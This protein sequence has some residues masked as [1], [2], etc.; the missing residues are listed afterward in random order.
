LHS[1]TN[2]TFTRVSLCTPFAIFRS[3]CKLL[4]SKTTGHDGIWVRMRKD[5]LPYIINTVT[6]TFNRILIEAVFAVCWKLA[7]VTPVYEGGDPDNPSN[8]CS[9]SVLPT[10]SKVFEKTHQC[11]SPGSIW[12]EWS[13]RSNPMTFRSRFSCVDSLQKVIADLLQ[14]KLNKYKVAL[15]FLNFSKAFHC[16]IEHRTLLSKIRRLLIWN[17]Q[18]FFWCLRVYFSTYFVYYLH[19]QSSPKISICL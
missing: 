14:C 19:W 12:S 11:L 18:C 13:F 3:P 16:R 6:D 1:H 17:F 8:C 4:L 7:R 5:S 15:R 2:A 9:I 10:L